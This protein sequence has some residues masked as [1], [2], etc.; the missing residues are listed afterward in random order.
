MPSFVP[1]ESFTFSLEADRALASLVGVSV[2]NPRGWSVLPRATLVVFDGPEDEGFLLPRVD[3]R[4]HDR[5][6]P[7]WD[8]A[9][10]RHGGAWLVVG[11]GEAL[12]TPLVA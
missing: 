12:F 3:E 1:A 5:A 2:A 4:G 8:E 10:E 6:P 11:E 7:G 9:V